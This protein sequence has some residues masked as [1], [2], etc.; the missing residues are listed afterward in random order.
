MKVA[1]L[2]VSRN[3]PDLVA[4]LASYLERNSSIDHDLYVIEAGTD[5]DKL[6]EHSTVRYA[7]DDFRGKAFAHN[8][9]LEEAR[10]AA[11]EKGEHYDYYWILMNDLVFPEGEDAMRTLVKS[12]EASPKLGILSPT[13]ADGQYPSSKRRPAGGWRPVTTC[14]Y[15]GFMI[16]AEIVE[17]IGFLNPDF[18]YCWGAIH[19]LAHLCYSHGWTVAYSDDVEYQHLGGTTY[20][21]PGTRTISREEYQ[22]RAKR[23]A[24]SYFSEVYGPRWNEVFWHV[25]RNSAHGSRIEVDT[26][27]DHRSYWASALTAEERAAID[28]PVAPTSSSPV[29]A[30]AP[31]PMS[32]THPQAMN[33]NQPVKLHLGC[34]PDSRDGWV[35]VDVN[36]R[37]APDLV[38]PAD[39]LPMLTDGSCSVIEACHLFEHLTLTQARAALREWRRLLIPGGELQ[40]ELPNLTRCVELVGTDMDGFDLGMISLFGYPPEVDQ[41]GEPQLHKWGWTPDTLGAELRRAGFE[42]VVQV[43]ITQ[44]HRKAARFNRDMRLIACA[45]QPVVAPVPTPAVAAAP[46]PS[47]ETAPAMQAVL[48]WPSY[49]DAAALDSFFHVFARV[50]SDRTDVGLFLRVDPELD[51]PTSEVLAALQ[52]AH[53]R[54]LGVETR[55]QIE[56]LEGELTPEAW[57]VIGQHF[58][59]RIRSGS[60]APPRDAIRQVPAPVVSDATGLFS[61]VNGGQCA[62]PESGD[63]NQESSIEA[64]LLAN[65]ESGLIIPQG[66]FA[67]PALARKIAELQPWFYPVTMDG[68]TVLPGIGSVCDV[69]WLA[70]RAACRATLLVEQVIRRIDMRGKSVLDLACNCAFWSSHYADAGATRVLGI[71]GRQRHVEQARLF[72][73]R[74]QFL[75]KGSY[76][77]EQGNISDASD[78]ES[79]RAEGPFDVTLCAGILYHVPNYIEV[80]TWAAEATREYLIVDTRVSNEAERLET[81]PGDLTFNAIA[82]TRDKVVPNLQN[83][84]GALR[85]LGF[86]PEVMPVGFERQLGVDNV[87][88]YADGSRVT[89]VAQKVAVPAIQ[90]P[91]P[92]VGGSV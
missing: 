67:D 49:G 35:N 10:R 71:E 13:C 50:L 73:D 34:G 70:N 45:P 29:P 14:D 68:F 18:K 30:P 77:F 79:I 7:D 26:F 91:S 53:A 4:S 65:P 20:G 16:R 39:S 66:T 75:P 60:D 33:S 69:E 86:A 2:V 80:L 51:P 78:W 3:R 82:E 40:L 57:R 55:L 44:T 23:H 61:L 52:A 12:M 92:L 85:G 84:L 28:A 64:E 8:V 5:D 54:I 21:A 17:T 19:E 83:L 72:W 41:Q 37:F 1:V 58:V 15:L 63:S 89:I 81:E 36:E 38:A 25:A 24:Y 56:L 22:K 47:K 76:R 27:S 6:C 31:S 11:R 88:S 32:P 9:A 59:C 48:A 43:P 46:Q 62:Q 90:R 87:D 74:N 42:S